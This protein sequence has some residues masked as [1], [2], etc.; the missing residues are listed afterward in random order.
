MLPVGKQRRSYERNLSLATKRVY[1][2]NL[3][4]ANHCRKYFL[5][6]VYHMYEPVTDEGIYAELMRFHREGEG[7]LDDQP[8]KNNWNEE[9]PYFH[10]YEYIMRHYT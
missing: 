8:W 10:L 5:T 9:D 7:E 4:P 1:C 2:L 6:G 3:H